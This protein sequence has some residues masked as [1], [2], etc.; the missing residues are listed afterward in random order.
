MEQRTAIQAA[1]DRLDRDDEV[2]FISGVD[3][4][5]VASIRDGSH[6]AR[7]STIRRLAAALDLDPDELIN[8]PPVA[9]YTDDEI[10]A[11]LDKLDTTTVGELA[12]A[13][14]AIAPTLTDE[15][16]RFALVLAEVAERAADRGAS[17][18]EI[19][20]FATTAW[21]T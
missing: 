18:D 11:V 9:T 3:P 12:N 6:K 8:G 15:S 17:I 20:D 2:A 16:R 7:P 14:R 4:R 10:A 13:I 19:R 1:L 5:T 21:A